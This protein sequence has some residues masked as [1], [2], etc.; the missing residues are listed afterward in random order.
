M[1]PGMGGAMDL[2]T[3]AR[4]VIVVMEHCAKDGSPKILERCSLP[5][6]ALAKVQ[7]IISE[8]AVFD[9]QDDTLI[10]QEIAPD[11]S[12]ESLAKKTGATFVVSKK[13]VKML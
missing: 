6:T 1:V 5:L 7:R 4:K 9:I 8:L 10:L 13:L 12:L 11:I 2:V 3:G